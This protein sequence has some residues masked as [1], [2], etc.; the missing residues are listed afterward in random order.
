MF[1]GAYLAIIPVLKKYNMWQ[2]LSLETG[3]SLCGLPTSWS[4]VCVELTWPEYQTECKISWLTTQLMDKLRWVF[5]SMSISMHILVRARVLH[6]VLRTDESPSKMIP[7]GSYTSKVI[8]H[9]I[10]IMATHSGSCK[11]AF[12][13]YDTKCNMTLCPTSALENVVSSKL[14]SNCSALYHRFHS[15][16][17]FYW[18]NE[19]VENISLL[20]FWWWRWRSWYRFQKYPVN[21]GLG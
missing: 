18:S 17:N 21:V 3:S 11:R 2:G 8:L 12:S 5:L 16:T 9:S 6:P 7:A 4:L 10:L 1:T 19:H 20:M 13:V 15:T 14:L